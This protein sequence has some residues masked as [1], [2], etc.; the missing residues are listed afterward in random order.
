M[1]SDDFKSTHRTP[2]VWALAAAFALAAPLAHAGLV[3]NGDFETGDLSG[4]TQTGNTDSFGVD[5]FAAQSG[6]FGA[7]FGPEQPGTLSQSI[8]TVAGQSYKVDF[9]LQ[10]DD[11]AQPN[12]FSWS[13]GGVTQTP[14][15]V[16]VNGFDYQEFSATV[17]ATG[18][19]STL[20]FTFENPQSFWLLDNVSVAAV[21]EPGTYALVSAG[22]LA[23]AALGRRKKRGA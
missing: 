16:N 4:W 19:F 8:A 21:P 7:F 23:I 2:L 18:A 6:T 11:S 3:I 12:S 10:L 17:T 1:K 9:W 14:N 20:A 22:L 13:L 15:L 5:P